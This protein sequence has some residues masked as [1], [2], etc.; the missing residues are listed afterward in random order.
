MGWRAA[1]H[2]A[3][4]TWTREHQW[5]LVRIRKWRE[6]KRRLTATHANRVLEELPTLEP[7]HRVSWH[8]EGGEE[9]HATVLYSI[10]PLTQIIAGL[11][12]TRRASFIHAPPPRVVC[13]SVIK[14]GFQWTHVPRSLGSSHGKRYPD[15]G[16]GLLRPSRHW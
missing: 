6:R 11:D 14:G 9:A 2:H 12:A 8:F 4:R 7:P 15:G 16:R 3:G 13:A 5:V 10:H 1:S